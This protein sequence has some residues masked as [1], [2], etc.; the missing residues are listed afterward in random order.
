LKLFTKQHYEAVA[1]IIA[2]IKNFEDRK[3]TCE[4]FVDL[5]RYD[6]YQFMP[7]F[8]R[9]ACKVQFTEHIF[10]AKRYYWTTDFLSAEELKNERFNGEKA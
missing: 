9:H 2:A 3:A 4:R 7:S 6:N 8:F 1:D 10:R 5:F